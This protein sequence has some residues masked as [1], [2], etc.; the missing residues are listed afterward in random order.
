MGNWPACYAWRHLG[1]W[2]QS[3]VPERINDVV[4][5]RMLEGL[6]L[7]LGTNAVV[8]FLSAES[9]KLVTLLF[10]TTIFG[11]SVGQDLYVDPITGGTCCRR[12]ITASFTLASEPRRASTCV[13]RRWSGEGSVSRTKSRIPRSSNLGG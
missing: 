3:A 8:E 13:S 4:E 9:D 7:P 1:S 6:G 5:L 12:T 2:P 11:W 10:S